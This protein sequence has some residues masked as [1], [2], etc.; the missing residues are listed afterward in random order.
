MPLPPTWSLRPIRRFS[1][2]VNLLIH[3]IVANRTIWFNATGYP[4]NPI[5][6]MVKTILS[7]GFTATGVTRKT[8]ILGNGLQST[9]VVQTCINIHTSLR[10]LNASSAIKR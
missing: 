7:T 4:S 1:K 2:S 6:L 9:F 10:T 3:A 5:W 8:E